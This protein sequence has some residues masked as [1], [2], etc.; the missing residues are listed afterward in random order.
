MSW[1]DHPPERDEYASWL[2]EQALAEFDRQALEAEEQALQTEEWLHAQMQRAADLS[3]DP[4]WDD[5]QRRIDAGE[6]DDDIYPDS[7]EDADLDDATRA[8]FS[9]EIVPGLHR[10]VCFPEPPG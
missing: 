4:E 10:H 3:A 8:Y 2:E 1:M 7:I 9:N 6:Y 5:L